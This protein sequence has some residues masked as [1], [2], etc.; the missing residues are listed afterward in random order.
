MEHGG[1][2]MWAG[3]RRVGVERGIGGGEIDIK[4]RLARRR[5]GVGAAAE[6][7]NADEGTAE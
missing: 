6:R 3:T 7:R 1:L 4:A 2:A 5:A